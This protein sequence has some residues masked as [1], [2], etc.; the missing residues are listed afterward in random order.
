MN[1]KTWIMVCLVAI[2]LAPAG[3]GKKESQP[4]TKP[5]QITLD[6]PKLEAAFANASP[7]LQA[8]SQEASRNIKFGRSYPAGLTALDKLANSPGITDEQKKVV[9]DVTA[10]VKQL[11]GSGAA[12]AQ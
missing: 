7:E 2:A 3:C 6:W 10:Q 9:A 1:I 8:L 12:P 11:M 5:Q 4:S